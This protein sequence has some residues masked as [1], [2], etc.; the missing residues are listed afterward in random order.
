MGHCRANGGDPKGGS[1]RQAAVLDMTYEFVRFRALSRK[2]TPGNGG[3]SIGAV[4]TKE[5][6]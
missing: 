5:F 2:A 6:V 3:A 4:S 1:L